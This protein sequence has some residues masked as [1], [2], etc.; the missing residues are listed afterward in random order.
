MNEPSYTY[1]I[2]VPFGHC[3]IAGIVYTPRFADYCMEAAEQ[4]L[5]E[6]IGLDWYAINLAGS[7]ANPVMRLDLQFH[8]K[9]VIADELRLLVAVTDIGRSSFTLAVHGYIKSGDG[10]DH[11]FSAAMVLAFVDLEAGKSIPIPG[12]YRP[13]LELALTA[14]A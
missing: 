10:R 12:D 9:V 11:A 6:R 1:R 14:P 3:D 4:F 2:S 7:Y 8:A 5:K 13:H